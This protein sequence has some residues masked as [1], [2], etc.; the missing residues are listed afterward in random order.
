[1]CLESKTLKT[2][3]IETGQVRPSLY[4]IFFDMIPDKLYYVEAEST[5]VHVLNKRQNLMNAVSLFNHQKNLPGIFGF[6]DL[7]NVYLLRLC[8]NIPNKDKEFECV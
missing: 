2:L 5:I 3:T 4:R 8:S 6:H 7:F 1:M